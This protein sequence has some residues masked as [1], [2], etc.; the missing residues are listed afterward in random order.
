MCTYSTSVSYINNLNLSSFLA[1]EVKRKCLLEN[2]ELNWKCRVRDE[3]REALCSEDQEKLMEL[4]K[5]KSFYGCYL[6]LDQLQSWKIFRYTF[7]YHS[8]FP[9]VSCYY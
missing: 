4:L 5:S 6:L 1:C 3:M 8:T 7:R 9:W 2:I